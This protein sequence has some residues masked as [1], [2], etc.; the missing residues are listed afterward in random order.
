MCIHFDQ[1]FFS[2]AGFPQRYSIF[3][4]NK[5]NI[6]N[7]S[8]VYLPSDQTLT[9][10]C[11]DMYLR[12]I[13]YFDTQLASI[14]WG[15]TSSKNVIRIWL[16]VW[17]TSFLTILSLSGP[18][19]FYLFPHSLMYCIIST[20][21]YPPSYTPLPLSCQCLICCRYKMT[22]FAVIEHKSYFSVWL[23]LPATHRFLT[24]RH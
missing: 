19:H 21:P 7:Y 15:S 5:R 2:I 8:Y 4:H 9:Q 14:S 13:P 22:L 16:A 12:K 17:V 10:A 6:A 11:L 20:S 18:F 3:L 24:Q 1:P 23:S